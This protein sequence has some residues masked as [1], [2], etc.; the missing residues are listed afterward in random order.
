MNG[1]PSK[2]RAAA[3]GGL[4][5]GAASAVPVVNFLNCAC[6]SLVVLGGVLSAHL[7]LKNAPP[8]AEP[9][10]GDV[11]IVGLLA[12]LIGAV[13]TAVLSLPF[14]FLGTGMG[15]YTAMQ[16][17]A[18]EADLP[19]PLRSMLATAGSGTLAMGM[20]LVSFVLNLFVYSLFSTLGALLGAAL[21]G[22]RSRPVPPAPLAPPPP[23]APV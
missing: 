6:C 14:A 12:G 19:E 15:M 1:G 13:V 22:R 18:A 21:F 2:M 11:A 4:A 16:E 8:A 20:I 5:L 7:Y 23:P 9:P 3:M 17:A 10:W